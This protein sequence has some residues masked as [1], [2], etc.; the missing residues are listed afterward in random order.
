MNFRTRAKPEISSRGFVTEN[1]IVFIKGS[2]S[3]RMERAVESLLFDQANKARLL[4]R[5]EPE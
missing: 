4:V 3:M 5:Q 1:D 2:Q